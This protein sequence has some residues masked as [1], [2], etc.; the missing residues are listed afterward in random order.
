MLHDP[1]QISGVS[2]T[3]THRRRRN[4]RPDG[5]MGIYGDCRWAMAWGDRGR[6]AE[7][8]RIFWAEEA[9][10]WSENEWHE[11]GDSVAQVVW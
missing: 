9:G 6:L 4:G 1:C 11:V 5:T 3:S 7:S 10:N 8:Q 2:D